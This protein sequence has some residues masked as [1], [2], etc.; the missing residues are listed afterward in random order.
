MQVQAVANVPGGVLAS[1]AY[2][3]SSCVGSTNAT[4]A[5]QTLRSVTAALQHIHLHFRAFRV[6]RDALVRLCAAALVHPALALSTA[7]SAAQTQVASEALATDWPALQA[8]SFGMLRSLVQQDDSPRKLW[9]GTTSRLLMPA[10]PFM[11]ALARVEG[12]SVDSAQ[13]SMQNALAAVLLQPEHVR[14]LAAEFPL[15]GAATQ[16]YVASSELATGAAAAHAHAPHGRSYAAKVLLPW[17]SL[18]QQLGAGAGG[19]E[20]SAA[21]PSGELSSAK[22]KR[23]RQQSDTEQ[24]ALGTTRALPQYAAWLVSEFAVSWRAQ[25]QAETEGADAMADPKRTQQPS[26]ET[27][28]VQGAFGVLQGVLT[29]SLE[30]MDAAAA[31][32]G[33]QGG[34]EHVRDTADAAAASGKKRRK[35][36]SAEAASIAASGSVRAVGGECPLDVWCAGAETC[37]ALLHAAA[38]AQVWPRVQSHGSHAHRGCTARIQ[39]PRRLMQCSSD[40]VSTAAISPS[41]AARHADLPAQHRHPWAPVRRTCHRLHSSQICACTRTSCRK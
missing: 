19:A 5:A 21:H 4:S 10:L 20:E 23:K 1:A 34:S 24:C 15:P 27:R 36:A 30:L 18:Y 37:A 14:A 2:A 41:T 25:L 11:F 32:H 28:A 16:L 29:A 3:V 22:R 8:L 33:R 26:L 31:V 17:Q 7:Q 9:D 40:L 6:E 38:R 35:G 13:R 39:V 12:A